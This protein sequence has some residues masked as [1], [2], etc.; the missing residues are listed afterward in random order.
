[1]RTG[2]PARRARSI[3]IIIGL[4]SMIFTGIVIANDAVF[5]QFMWIDKRNHPGGPLGYL[6]D[7][8]SIWFQTWGTAANMVTNF[9]GDAL[10]VRRS[11]S[12]SPFRRKLN[13]FSVDLP[14]LHHL[15]GEHLGHCFPNPH[16]PWLSLYVLF[17]T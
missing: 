5:M 2:G 10:L 1:M 3:Y 12:G 15:A 13:L 8:S 17:S 11:F 4:L 6:A 7:N 14:P 16:L 9:I